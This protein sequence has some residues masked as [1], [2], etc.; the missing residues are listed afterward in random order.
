[1][2]CKDILWVIKANPGTP[3]FLF[4]LVLFFLFIT[5]RLQ[6]SLQMLMEKIKNEFYI[7]GD[8][9]VPRRWLYFSFESK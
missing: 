9:K 7:T 3:K 4:F 2:V 8:K 6:G 1:M 5:A